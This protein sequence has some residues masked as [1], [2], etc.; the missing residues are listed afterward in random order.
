[1]LGIKGYVVVV[2]VVVVFLELNGI[3]VKGPYQKLM[4]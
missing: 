1:L 2:V 4:Q 3:F